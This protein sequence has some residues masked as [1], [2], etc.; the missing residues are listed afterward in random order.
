MKSKSMKE[1]LIDTRLLNRKNEK[2]I[3][4]HKSGNKEINTSILEKKKKSR[5]KKLLGTNNASTHDLVVTSFL[6]F[7]LL[8]F[9]KP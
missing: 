3:V 5:E 7:I 6:A 9:M 8:S 2:S 1:L 4:L